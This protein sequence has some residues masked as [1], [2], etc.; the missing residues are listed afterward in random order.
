MI[1]LTSSTNIYRPIQQVF[2]FI[3]MPENDFL[4]Q[5]GTLASVRLFEGITGTGRSFRS[6]GHFMG[7]RMQSTFEVTAYEPNSRYAFKSISGN[8]Q[9]QTSYTFETIKGCTV[10]NLSMQA[11]MLDP[12]PVSE[13]V[14]EKKMRKQF[15]ENLTLLKDVLEGK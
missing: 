4:W 2:E 8:L 14:L 1:H 3:S 12:Q 9:S 10:V 11:A 6:I 7:L 15:K 13:F 5:Y